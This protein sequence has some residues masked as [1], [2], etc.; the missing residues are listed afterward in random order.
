[1]RSAYSNIWHASKHSLTKSVMARDLKNTFV[2]SCPSYS[3]WFKIFVQGIHKRMGDE[4]H[5][6]QAIALEVVHRLVEDLENNYQENVGAD[7]REHIANL[8][9]LILSAFLVAFR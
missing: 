2:T 5:Q 8:A 3:L 1:M 7:K 9:V 6:N 4:V